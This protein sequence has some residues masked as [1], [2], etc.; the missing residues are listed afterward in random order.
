MLEVRPQHQHLPLKQGRLAGRLMRWGG[1]PR[2]RLRRG[3]GRGLRGVTA[4]LWAVPCHTSWRLVA[5]AFA[6]IGGRLVP[7]YTSGVLGGTNGSSHSSY[8]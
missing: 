6:V 3:P 2:R 4:T 7:R 5:G 1:S 8:P